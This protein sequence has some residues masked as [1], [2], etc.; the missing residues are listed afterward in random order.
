MT[1]QPTKERIM[2][3]KGL[4]AL[5]PTSAIQW[6]AGATNDRDKPTE[7]L[8]LAYIDARAVQERLDQVCGPEGWQDEYSPIQGGFLCRLS[9][10][11]GEDWIAKEDGADVSAIEPTK[12]GVSDS[13]KRAAVKWGIGRYLYDLPSVWVPCEKKGKS[14]VL[15]QTPQLPT[16][17]VPM[18]DA[19][20]HRFVAKCVSL[21]S[22][23]GDR[24][25]RILE[26]HGVIP[27]DVVSLEEAKR[28]TY[29]LDAA[30]KQ[31]A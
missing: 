16:W 4:T 5:L 8:A 21:S 28:L 18:N 22:R 10:R 31:A 27:E 2:D 26:Q 23:L 7:A 17:A 24:Y 25:N 15:K 19:E 14:V 29:A 1:E 3:T 13:F 11:Y 20:R 30:L 12:G 6:R 9:I